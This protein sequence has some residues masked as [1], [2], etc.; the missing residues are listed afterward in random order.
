VHDPDVARADDF[1]PAWSLP[2]AISSAHL[3]PTTLAAI[4]VSTDRV[5]LSLHLPLSELELAFRHNVTRDPDTTI[6]AWG[7]PVRQYLAADIHPVSPDGHAWHV[8]PLDMSLSKSE[9]AQSGPFQEVNVRLAPAGPCG[10]FPV[11]RQHDRDPG[12]FGSPLP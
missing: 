10:S 6:S 11:C 7:E 8:Q 4:D 2:S 3:Q 12:G 9:Q 5:E 1:I